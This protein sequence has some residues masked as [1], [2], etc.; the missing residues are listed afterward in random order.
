MLESR[1]QSLLYIFLLNLQPRPVS[2][3]LKRT[4]Q[5]LDT[6]AVRK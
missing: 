6:P 5:L 3:Q 1:M 2:L 4:R